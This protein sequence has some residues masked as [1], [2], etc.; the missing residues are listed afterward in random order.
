MGIS[1]NNNNNNNI[2]T[3]WKAIPFLCKH[4]F[5][6]LSFVR[7]LKRLIGEEEKKLSSIDILHL[8]FW[9]LNKQIDLFQ[10]NTSNF[11]DAYSEWE[12]KQS[13]CRKKRKKERKSRKRGERTQIL[14]FNAMDAKAH[15]SWESWL[16]LILLPSI[17]V[18]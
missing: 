8:V 1:H 2:S 3:N 5:L 14:K 10:P 18:R 13:R 17:T 7:D 6:H 15:D 4:L 11:R 9:N 12:I 16:L